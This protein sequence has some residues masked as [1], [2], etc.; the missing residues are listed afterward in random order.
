[1]VSIYDREIVVLVTI[2]LRI[3]RDDN[4]NDNND[5]MIMQVLKDILHHGR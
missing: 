1:M 3:F 4:N 2:F 5:S